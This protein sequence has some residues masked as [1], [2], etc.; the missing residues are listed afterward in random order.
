MTRPVEGGESDGLVEV[1]AGTPQAYS[2]RVGSD[3]TSHLPTLLKGVCPGG[4]VALISDSNV[5]PLHGASVQ[6]TLERSGVDVLPL[7]FPSGEAS[8]TRKQWS[9]LTDQML[10][11]GL[12]RDA[13]VVAL[14][15]GVTTDLA[16]FVAA[17]F[18]RGIPVV[19]LPTSTLAM[20]DASVGSKT[21]V[22]VRN[23]KN[24][25]G[26]FHAPAGVLADVSRL[27]TLPELEVRA[28]LVEAVKH[29]VI[30][31]AGH[32]DALEEVIYSLPKP[33]PKTLIPLLV[34]SVRIKAN[35]V[36]QDEYESGP[37]QIL[38]FGHTIG[39]AIE[40]ASDFRVGHGSAVAAGMVAE[41]ELGERM[42]VTKEGTARHLEAI[43]DRLLAVPTRAAW[44]RVTAASVRERMVVDKKAR[45]GRL[46]FVLL[47]NLGKIAGA[48]PWTHA[49]P[50]HLVDDV[51]RAFA[52]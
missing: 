26:A 30:R 29:G 20:V 32:L 41:A 36:E 35:V 38:N 18:M 33:S 9:I 37:R 12:G 2:V 49:A 10:D 24:L 19:Q 11:A 46:R 14:G 45:E 25:V 6:E 23:G 22:D 8:K 43:L 16:G 13:C 48:P 3:A 21:G 52:G 31:Q 44:D 7:V 40:S 27:E 4:R 47:K 5:A 1:G 17:T 51:I 28:G 39:H 15:G 34:Q 42:G 50:D